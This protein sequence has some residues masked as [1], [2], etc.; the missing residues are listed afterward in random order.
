MSKTRLSLFYLGS[1]LTVIG[2]GLLFTPHTTLKIL[3]SNGNYGDV[4]PRVA[5]MLMSG[6]GLSIFGMIRA[7]SSE[8]YPATLFIRVYF[9]ACIVAFYAMTG[10]PLFLVLVG[11]I[12]L[13]FAL[14]LAAH[15]LDRRDHVEIEAWACCA[16]TIRRIPAYTRR[17]D[18]Q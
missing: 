5:G 17:G 3:Q 16:N 10:D 6:L 13:G 12:G 7:R 14:T 11:I 9:I 4:F 15:L 1:Y 8:L 2:F 18:S